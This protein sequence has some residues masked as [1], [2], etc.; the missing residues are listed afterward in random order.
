MK[1]KINIVF[2]LILISYKVSSQ[3]LIDSS[4]IVRVLSFNILHGE[5]TK[6]DFDLEKIAKVIKNANSD[7]VAMK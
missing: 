6:G 1:S 4:K 5:T 3:I 7:F 2:V